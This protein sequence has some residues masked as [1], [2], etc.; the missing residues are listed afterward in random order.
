[1]GIKITLDKEG[2]QNLVSIKD[3]IPCGCQVEYTQIKLKDLTYYTFA[4]ES[5]GESELKP[6]NKF[7]NEILGKTKLQLEDSMGYGEF[8]KKKQNS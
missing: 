5:F 6:E 2:R 1:M 4:L 3:R 7:V 8:L